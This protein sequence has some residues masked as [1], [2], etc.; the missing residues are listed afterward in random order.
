MR[1]AGEVT[2]ADAHKKTRNEAV[3]CFAS[4]EDLRRALDRYQGKD[5]NGRRIK[6]VDD[7]DGYGGGGGGGGRRSRSRSRSRSA[8]RS[9]SRS[10]PSRS[11]SPAEN[12]RSRSRTRSRSRSLSSA[13][14]KSG[15]PECKTMTN[16]F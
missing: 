10:P 1:N 15:S 4:H 9:R 8:Y 7:S 3:I 16:S 13:S 2:Y 14:K 11:A 6:L 12:G 5:I